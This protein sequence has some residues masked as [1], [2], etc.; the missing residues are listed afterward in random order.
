MK[1]ILF[2]NL[3]QTIQSATPHH[4]LLRF[5]G[6]SPELKHLHKQWLHREIAA[7]QPPAEISLTFNLYSFT[8]IQSLDSEKH[9]NLWIVTIYNIFCYITYLDILHILILTRRE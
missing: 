1:T 3:G 9:I 6:E 5:S 8:L 7:G 2:T 4:I